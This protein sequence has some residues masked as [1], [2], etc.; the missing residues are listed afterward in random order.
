MDWCFLSRQ[1]LP[2]MILVF[3]KSYDDTIFFHNAFPSKKQFERPNID[4]SSQRTPGTHTGTS[5]TRGTVPKAKTKKMATKNKLWKK[6]PEFKGFNLPKMPILNSGSNHL[7]ILVH[8]HWM[9]K[10]LHRPQWNQWSPYK[11]SGHLRLGYVGLISHNRHNLWKQSFAFIWISRDILFQS[12]Q[13]LLLRKTLW[14]LGF[15]TAPE[16]ETPLRA[17]LL[18]YLAHSPFKR[19]GQL[20]YQTSNWLEGVELV[21]RTGEL[22]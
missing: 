11:I 19:L 7:R 9:R 20:V 3:N 1:K 4:S 12:L 16:S 15:W 18:S 21:L 14:I 13:P 17:G 2:L 5:S 8:T 10:C 6:A 22:P